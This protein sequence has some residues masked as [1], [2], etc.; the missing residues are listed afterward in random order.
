MRI[1]Q[2]GINFILKHENCKL[3]LYKDCANHYT[4]GVGHKCSAK[5][6]QQFKNGISKHTALQLL[7]TDL[8]IPTNSVNNLGLNL[9]QNQAD[10]LISLIFNIGSGNFAKSTLKQ[11]LLQN[12]NNFTDIK[13]NWLKFS[14]AN[15]Q[16]VKGL[17][18]RRLNETNL[19]INN[20]Y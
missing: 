18:N 5:Q 8:I 10:A 11:I 12:C 1:S 13:N 2:Q 7:Y 3:T 15:K 19:Y 17:L 4:I 14:Y 6:I 9:L 20:I 16:F